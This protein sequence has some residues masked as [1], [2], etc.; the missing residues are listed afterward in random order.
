MQ[1]NVIIETVNSKNADGDY[2]GVYD[3][4]DTGL[5][6]LVALKQGFT[7]PK[8]IIL[9]LDY[10][11]ERMYELRYRLESGGVSHFMNEAEF[12]NKSTN[13]VVRLC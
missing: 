9:A 13:K 3:N 5:I 12:T 10:I 4:I 7:G 1:D 6:Q 8:Q 11:I 2:D